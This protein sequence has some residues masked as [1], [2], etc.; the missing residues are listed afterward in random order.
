MIPCFG[1]MLKE[2]REGVAEI[3]AAAAIAVLIMDRE[4]CE[5]ARSTL[6]EMLKCEDE[7]LKTEVLQMLLHI[8][9]LLTDA[10]LR[11]CLESDSI[12]IR[13]ETLKIAHHRRDENLIPQVID[14]LSC[15]QLRADARGLLKT[16]PAEKVVAAMDR[17]CYL[18]ETSTDHQIEIIRTLRVYPDLDSIR[19]LVSL[20]EES[21]IP[22]QAETID[23]LLEIARQNPLPESVLNQFKNEGS[24]IARE[25]YENYQLLSRINKTSESLLLRDLFKSEIQ[26]LVKILFKLLVL[27]EP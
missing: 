16:Y 15:P 22:I 26:R 14:C 18:P 4:F 13:M 11:E 21:S 3:R 8:P 9:T 27:R 5:V 17:A 1:D 25:I 24:K 7:T 23:T 2:G 12:R 19:C 20:F 6:S 10:Q